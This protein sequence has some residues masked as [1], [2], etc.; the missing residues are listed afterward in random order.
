MKITHIHQKYKMFPTTYSVDTSEW[1]GVTLESNYN[2]LTN[3]SW[4][5]GHMQLSTC[6]SFP[7]CV[8]VDSYIFV[9]SRVTDGCVVIWQ[10]IMVIRLFNTQKLSIEVMLG[11]LLIISAL[12]SRWKPI[13][14]NLW[15]SC[16]IVWSI[17]SDVG[18]YFRVTTFL[19]T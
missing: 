5:H 12:Y 1:F 9:S 8:W 16:Y 17:W 7:S 2:A 14:H 11:A 15:A 4:A 13:P 3:V 18:F 10:Y 6:T 19:A